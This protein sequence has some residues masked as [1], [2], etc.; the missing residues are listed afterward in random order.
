VIEAVFA[1][2]LL[3]AVRIL[4]V[5]A[6]HP[7]GERH[8][9]PV[10]L[11]VAELELDL[12]LAAVKGAVK[13][14]ELGHRRP[15]GRE[16]REL[17][18]LLVLERGRTLQGVEMIL[19]KRLLF[20]LRIHS[21]GRF[22][23]E[24]GAHRHRLFDTVDIAGDQLDLGLFVGRTRLVID[25]DPT[26]QLG[27]VLLRL[28]HGDIFGVPAQ[29]AGKI[30]DLGRVIARLAALQ[31][32]DQSRPRAQPLGQGGEFDALQLGGLEGLH[33]A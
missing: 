1:D 6:H 8:A 32:P 17:L 12:H 3:G 4:L 10:R 18:D 20:E 24:H 26:V 9:Q 19:E 11:T 23:A 16:E 31:L 2:E 7:L 15:R 33:L 28:Q 29:A 13:R 5:D 21:H 14:I 22:G 27:R 25:R 30:A